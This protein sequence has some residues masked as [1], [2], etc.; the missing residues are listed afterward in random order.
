M[1]LAITGMH[2]TGMAAAQFA[3]DSLCLAVDSTGGLDGGTL[4]VLVGAATLSILAITLVISAADAHYHA[5]AARLADS[6]QA[7]NE[8]LR[9]IALYDNL[10]GLPNRLLLEDRMGQAMRRADRGGSHFTVMFV[11]LDRF[12]PVNDNF[13]HRAGDEVLKVVAQRLSGCVRKADTVARAGG[14]EFVIVLSE[15]NAH[16]AS[17]VGRKILD[18]LSRPIRVERHELGISCSIGISVYPVD[19]RDMVTLMGNADA[20]MYQAKKDG[21]NGYRFFAGEICAPVPRAAQ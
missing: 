10:T 15:V 18:E 5:Q 1:G 11:D 4:A 12:K 3:P 13:G 20:A 16:D 19:G 9:N 21:R 6:L 8:Q 2:Y 7:A 14:D 17:L